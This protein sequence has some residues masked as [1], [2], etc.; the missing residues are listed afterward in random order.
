MEGR[1]RGE[2][3]IMRDVLEACL[4]GA[5][6]TKIVYGTNLNFS[7][8]EKYLGILLSLGFIAK[9]DNPAGSV[10]YKTTQAGMDF[11]GGCLKMQSSLRKVPV[12][13]V[14]RR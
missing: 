7:R 10:V 13:L 3:E 12:N 2:I 5:N 4:K 14:S 1:R 8:L 11:L 9:E 6:R